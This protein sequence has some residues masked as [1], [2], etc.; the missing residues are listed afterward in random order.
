LGR[1][2]GADRVEVRR[3]L[4]LELGGGAVEIDCEIDGRPLRS[5][6]ISG[7]HQRLLSLE[8]PEARVERRRVGAV[9]VYDEDREPG[10]GDHLVHV[11]S[12]HGDRL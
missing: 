11:D 3:D 10:V 4:L 6:D 5:A 12:R 7:A 1:E 2:H 8:R 9:F